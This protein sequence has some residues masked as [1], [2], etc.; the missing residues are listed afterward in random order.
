MG[1]PFGATLDLAQVTTPSAS[2]ASGRQL[3]YVKSDG[4]LYTKSNAGVESQ[5]GG[6]A[7]PSYTLQ[8]AHMTQSTNQTGVVTSTSTPATFNVVLTA[9]P[10]ALADAANNRFVVQVSAWHE[11][12]FQWRWAA[13]STGDRKGIIQVNGS[14]VAGDGRTAIANSN[15]MGVTNNVT[16]TGYLNAGDLVTFQVWQSSG[17]NLDSSTAAADTWCSIASVV[18]ATGVNQPMTLDTTQTVTGAK[19]FTLPVDTQAVSANLTGTLGRYVGAQA[20]T[21]PVSGT[22]AVGDF[23]TTQNGK[24]FVCQ[25]AGT[26]GTWTEVVPSNMMGT[27]SIQ[28]VTGQKT[29]TG[30]PIINTVNL[31]GNAAIAMTGTGPSSVGGTMQAQAFIPTGLTGAAAASRY[32]GAVASTAPASGT[33]ALGD[34]VISQTG[35]VFVCTSAGTPGTWTDVGGAGG[36]TSSASYSLS[37]DYVNTQPTSPTNGVTVFARH[38]ARR[39]LA[40]IGPSG[41]DTSYQPALFTNRVAQ[42]KAVN[43]ATTQQLDGLAVTSITAPTAVSVATTN[44][45]TSMVRQRYASTAVAGNA[46]GVR[47]ATAQWFLSSTANL[48]GLFFVCRFGLNATSATNRLFVGMSATTTA[49]SATVDPSTLLNMFGFGCNSAHTTMRFYCNDASGTATMTDLGANF[50]TQTAATYFYEVRLFAPSGGGLNVYWYAERLNDG[51]TANGQVTTDLPAV[52]TLLSAHVNHSN[53]TTAAAVSTD[54]QALYIETD[55]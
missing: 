36:G 8:Y 24:V 7:P 29:F 20:S 11:V 19:T 16:F 12:N 5:V 2:P 32:V 9:T 25:T 37:T 26:P 6:G 4:N 44:F 27:N 45:Y 47:S 23:V 22:Y 38:R 39:L 33:F 21:A 52:N 28:T 1:K 35:K 31:T 50:P 51:L 30:G 53:G 18:P 17:G 15:F 43:G 46:G 54:L 14:T 49:L 3:L 13:N 34:F 10:S 41:L 40:A 48:G 55:N 42:L